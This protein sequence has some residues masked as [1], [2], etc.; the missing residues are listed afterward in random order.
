MCSGTRDLADVVQ[1]GGS[2]ERL[3]LQLVGDVQLAREADRV[4]LD[5]V[6]VVA[7]D[8][9]FRID[10]LSQRLDGR[11]VDAVHLAEVIDLILGAAEGMP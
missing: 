6:D 10:R 8:L 9:V 5:A 1:E 2:L 11:D 4:V 3:N 7:G